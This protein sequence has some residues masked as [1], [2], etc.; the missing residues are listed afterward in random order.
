LYTARANILCFPIPKRIGLLQQYTT[1]S[2]NTLQYTATHC[3]TLQHTATH[4][5]TLQ[6]NATLKHTMFEVMHHRG[7]LHCVAACCSVLQCVAVCC[8]VLQCIV[9]CCS[10][11]ELR[12]IIMPTAHP[13]LKTRNKTSNKSAPFHKMFR[14]ATIYTIKELIL[15]TSTIN[16]FPLIVFSKTT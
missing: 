11:F 16:Q 14:H 6:H 3:N 4:C 2:C 12:A 10:V 15:N 9:V 7:V 5:N 8:S 13:R 1:T